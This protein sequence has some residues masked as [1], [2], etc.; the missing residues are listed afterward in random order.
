MV[1]DMDNIQNNE[2]IEK[3][4][5]EN[6][7]LRTE[8]DSTKNDLA[9]LTKK[10]KFGNIFNLLPE[11]VF[12]LDRNKVIVELNKKAKKWLGCK[13]KEIVGKDISSIKYFA[14]EYRNAISS[15]FANLEK[16]FSIFP[17]EIGLFDHNEIY[18]IGLA[19]SV[20]IK[21]ESKQIT[22]FILHISDITEMKATQNAFLDSEKKFKIVS[23]AGDCIIYRLDFTNMEY[24]YLNQAFE[25]ITGYSIDEINRIKFK[26]II[27]EIE[28]LDEITLDEIQ[29]RRFER[30]VSEYNAD[31]LIETKSGEMKW[32]RDHSN[33]WLNVAGKVIGSIGIMSDVTHRKNLE[34]EN[35]RFIEELALNKDLV[36]QHAYEMVELN[37]KLEESEQKLQDLNASKDRFFS[38]I[39]HDLRSPF[40]TF[41]GYTEL[42]VDDFDSF[43]AD[44]VKDAFVTIHK[45]SKKI[46]DLLDNLLNW[47]QVQTGRM[48][49]EPENLSV[50]NICKNIVELFEDNAR[51]KNI[52]LHQEFDT[53][54][55]V[56]ADNNMLNTII[57]NLVSNALKFTPANNS[58]VLSAKIK[59]EFTE[60]SV[61]DT[62]LG[63]KP[64]NLNKLFRIDQH[65]TTLGTSNEKGSGL[66]LILCKELVE[67]NGGII[68]VES[69]LDKG[70]R[71]FFT[72]PLEKE[73]KQV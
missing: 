10:N 31:Y 36:E 4:N 2:I 69:E 61:R 60:I 56:F 26:S 13:K 33:P 17:F 11:A 35:Q 70:S 9:N 65:V 22:G 24:D 48:P 41:M 46:Y 64:E 32:L 25:R 16:G 34:H 12:I 29:K 40:T 52:D 68:G 3:L 39:A 18:Y 23:Q 5:A 30:L 20:P 50:N 58:I 63:I 28:T 62:G 71:F 37:V 8:L 15:S 38:I 42:F 72:I 27:R 1:S 67:K 43:S 44:E 51:A 47:A 45:T 54:I 19:T 66:G 73:N 6:L 57:R 53:E 14:K 7:K 21:N 55:R 49:F 59:G